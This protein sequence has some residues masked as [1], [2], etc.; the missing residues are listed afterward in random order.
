VVIG[1]YVPGLSFFNVLFGDQPV[2]SPQAQYYQRLLAGDVNEAKQILEQYQKEKSLE[3]L[4]S[5]VVIPALALAEQDR[6]RNELD[7][8]TQTFIYQ[9]TREIIDELGADPLQDDAEAKV[10][11]YSQLPRLSKEA[12]ELLEVVC[13]PARDDA[14]EVVAMLLSQLL[15]RLGHNSQSIPLASSTEILR[16]VG[17][18]NPRVVCI[19]ALPPFAVGHAR[20]LYASLKA[21]PSDF[22]VVVCLWQ[23]DG[24]PLKTAALLKLT[25]GDGFF[26]TLPETLQH[27]DSLSSSLAGIQK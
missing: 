14:D 1:R 8:E 20:A 15:A 10:G 18:L 12:S 16:R 6:H 9:S 13:I 25:N 2:L 22:E 19:S 23:F 4:Y 11:S 27:V 24:D 3:E 26:T 21:H 7:D 5:A 17:E